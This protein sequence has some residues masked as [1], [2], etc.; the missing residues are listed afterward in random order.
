[1]RSGCLVD[2][3]YTYH[4][5]LV[6]ES[7]LKGKLELWEGF[8]RSKELRVNVKKTK[9]VISSNKARRLGKKGSFLVWSAE[10]V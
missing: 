1:M 9:L 2:L 8:L 3:L 5:V 6:N 7:L 4:L 10:K